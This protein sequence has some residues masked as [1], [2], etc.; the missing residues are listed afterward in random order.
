MG[1]SRLVTGVDLIEIERIEAALHRHADRFLNRVYTL[2]E[3]TYCGARIESLAARF[4][5]KEAAAKA[6]GTGIW[7]S[8]VTWT[9]IEVVNDPA[10]GTPKVYLHNAAAARAIALNLTEW[11]ISLSHDR[12]R[13]IAFVVALTTHNS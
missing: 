11:S 4:A 7:R 8:G 1:N 3:R 13:A 6:L 10:T 12:T 9:D 5:A 2:R